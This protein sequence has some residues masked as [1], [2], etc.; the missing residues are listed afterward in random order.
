MS[1]ARRRGRARR[2]ARIAQAL[3]DIEREA[4]ERQAED[5]THHAVVQAYVADTEAGR[6]RTGTPPRGAHLRAARARVARMEAAQ[7][8]KIETWTSRRDASIAA[9]GRG[10]RGLAPRPL[11][12]CVV[13]RRARASLERAERAERAADGQA[14]DGTT[15]AIVRNI[16]D[17]DSRL[18]PTR[19]G[20][21]QGYN[22]QNVVSA[23]GLII[24]TRLTQTPGDVTWLTPMTDAAQ[25]AAT[26]LGTAHA[27]QAVIDD[28]PC[29]CPPPGTTA[30][31]A[32]N[33]RHHRPP[34]GLLLADAGYLSIANLTAPGPDRLIAVGKHRTLLAAARN[35]P[36]AD[37]PAADTPAAD[38]PAADTPPPSPPPP[39]TPDQPPD[40]IQQ[41]AT[42][43]RTPTG[44]TQYNQRG[45]LAETPHG[46][47]K[48]N[49]G[50][51]QL[52]MRGLTKASAEWTFVCATANL[53]KALSTAAAHNGLPHPH[54]G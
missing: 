52:S 32:P 39:D 31:T 54:T 34:I 9:G 24:A 27:D 2:A 28:L 53:F 33:C 6:A 37:T 26:L 36:A 10:L 41:M 25:Q 20:F 29:T 51:H 19:S 22:P 50:F 11:D 42:R 8:A 1:A 3:A 21:I 14:R 43:L 13:V 40:P 49:L 44:I 15:K 12:E 17:P 4:R 35:T 48:H 38:T 7:L 46:H 18:M 30:P 45:H 47:I 23:D 5:D 16:T